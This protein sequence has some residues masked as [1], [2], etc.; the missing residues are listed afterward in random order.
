MVIE[1]GDF[2]DVR[3]I[4]SPFKETA[5]S[6]PEQEDGQLWCISLPDGGASRLPTAADRSLLSAILKDLGRGPR[7]FSITVER[8]IKPDVR[9][10]VL[11]LQAE[12]VF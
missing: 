5:T 10:D 12:K 4:L 9:K 2:C 1:L 6:F 8:N 3:T 7:A 11:E